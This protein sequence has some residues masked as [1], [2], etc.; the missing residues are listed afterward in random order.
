MLYIRIL[1]VILLENLVMMVDLTKFHKRYVKQGKLKN[2][3]L[4]INKLNK[5]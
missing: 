3:V 5:K 1:R 4:E 2:N